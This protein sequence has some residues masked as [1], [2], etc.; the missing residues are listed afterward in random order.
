MTDVSVNTL[1][2][3]FK[4]TSSATITN[5]TIINVELNQIAT[6][7]AQNIYHDTCKMNVNLNITNT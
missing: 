2:T 1:E 5:K 4:L 7:F 6:I 3:N